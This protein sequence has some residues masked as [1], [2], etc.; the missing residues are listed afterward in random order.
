MLCSQTKDLST[1]GV[2]KVVDIDTQ[3]SIGGR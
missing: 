3:G 1:T 2:A